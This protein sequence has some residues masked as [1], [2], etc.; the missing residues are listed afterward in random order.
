MAL[1]LTL[2]T[3]TIQ[4][5]VDDSMV[6]PALAAL[7][8]LLL[9]FPTRIPV[10]FTADVTRANATINLLMQQ[11]RSLQALAGKRVVIQMGGGFGGGAGGLGG[12]MGLHSVLASMG[13]GA[14]AGPAMTAMAGAPGIAAAEAAGMAI[15][16]SMKLAAEIEKQM[17]VL[18]AVGDLS[19][20]GTEALKGRLFGI[21]ET[22]PGASIEDI[23]KIATSG[24][25]AGVPIQ[26]GALEEF[27]KSMTKFK[28]L[29]PEMDMEK[30]GEQT[31]RTLN[32]FGKGVGDVEGFA[33][34]LAKMDA[35]STASA[36]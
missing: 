17:S 24:A 19:K 1:N 3:G 2:A 21:S 12:A 29:V 35:S 16:G 6:R 22:A 10:T 36:A 18:R 25:R 34:A 14:A 33:S 5:V 32:I 13:L 31:L 15:T 23:I 4:V 11:V 26:G 9:R 30:L 8:N 28:L 20:E 7:R 27:T